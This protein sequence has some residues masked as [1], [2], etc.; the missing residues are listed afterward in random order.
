[1]LE[2]E[3]RCAGKS[4]VPCSE[5]PLR[6]GLKW[7]RR[8]RATSHGSLVVRSSGEQN[9]ATTHCSRRRARAEDVRAVK[10]SVATYDLPMV[11]GAKR[12][13]QRCRSGRTRWWAREKGGLRRE[14]GVRE[15]G[16]ASCRQAGAR[17]RLREDKKCGGWQGYSEERRWEIAAR[18]LGLRGLR[19]SRPAGGYV[20][21]R[22]L[23]RKVAWRNV[24]VCGRRR[25]V[26]YLRAG[27]GRNLP[28]LAAGACG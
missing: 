26:H 7:R 10:E 1:M 5:T 3:Q 28:G 12:D 19:R 14:E 18:G 21:H 27:S 24:G 17:S 6:R 11:D 16:R 25:V 22:H 20:K 23:S 8:D 9:V 13:V 15:G 2:L 4:R